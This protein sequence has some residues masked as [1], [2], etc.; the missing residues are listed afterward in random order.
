MGGYSICEKPTGCISSCQE[1]SDFTSLNAKQRGRVTEYLIPEKAYIKFNTND[2]SEQYI[3]IYIYPLRRRLST[4]Y[5]CTS[6]I[7]GNDKSA[8]S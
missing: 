4:V 2:V 1:K 3:Y 8:Y 5:V 6:I 7:A